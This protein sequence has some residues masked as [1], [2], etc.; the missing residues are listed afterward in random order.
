[1]QAIRFLLTITCLLFVHVAIL[2]GAYAAAVGVALTYACVNLVIAC[3]AG[4]RNPLR[5]PWLVPVILMVGAQ[6]A[7][8]AGY[9]SA[10]ALILMPSIV[11]NAFLLILFGHTLLPG[12]ESLITRFRRLEKGHVAPVFVSY[13]RHLT[14][15]WTTLFAIATA[16]SLAAAAWGDITLWSW[17]AVIAIPAASLLL[18]LGEHAYRAVRFGAEGRSSPLRTVRIMLHP[19][20]WRPDPAQRSGIQGRG[21][22]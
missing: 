8:W 20:A 13:T 19:D 22:D 15:L 9:R 10:V 4:G 12:Q 2:H 16:V 17:I 21:H 18:F 11:M 5:S 1:M 6:I 7:V 14:L 3:S